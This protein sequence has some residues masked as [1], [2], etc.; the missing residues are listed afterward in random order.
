MRKIARHWLIV[1]SLIAWQ[2]GTFASAAPMMPMVSDKEAVPCH[3]MDMPVDAHA[4]HAAPHEPVATDVQGADLPPC[5]AAG[6]CQGDCMHSQ[7]LSIPVLLNL[8]SSRVHARV[9][10]LRETVVVARVAEFFRPPI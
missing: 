7:A 2:V 4:S 3:G 6:T 1:A 9:V 8:E 5:C 10:A